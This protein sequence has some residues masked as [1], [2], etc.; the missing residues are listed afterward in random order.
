MN[1]LQP[2]LGQDKSNPLFEILLNPKI[3]DLLF[4]YFGMHLLEKINRASLEEKFLV[5]RLFNAKFSRKEL[6]KTF[7]Y[8][9]KTM[10]KWG[11]ALHTGNIE[12]ILKVFSGNL[13]KRKITKDIEKFIRNLYHE[14]YNEYGCHS[15]EYIRSRVE[16]IFEVPIS[17]ESIRIILREEKSKFLTE[18]EKKE[19]GFLPV[20]HSAASAI[21]SK[22]K[23]YFD[24]ISEG[25]V[26]A[27]NVVKMEC[28][29]GNDDNSGTNKDK[30]SKYIPIL[31]PTVKSLPK[32]NLFLHHAGLLTA[33]IFIDETTMH[34][35]ADHHNTA[36]QW[37]SMILCGCINIEQGQMLNYK[38]L[39]FLLGPQICSSLRQRKALINISIEQNIWELLRE[40]IRLVGAEFNDYFLYDPHSI[41]YT[42]QVKTLK[43]WIGSSH[44]TGKVYYQDFMHTVEGAPVFVDLDDNFYDLRGRFIE[45]INKFRKI[46]NGDK[47][48]PLNIIVDRAIY[49]VD[50]MKSCRTHNIFIITW[51]K[52]YR[53][54]R[55][56]MEFEE[57]AVQFSI[58]RYKNSNDDC[59]AYT[60]KYVKSVWEKDSSFV[61]YTVMLIKNKND[62]IELSII[63]SDVNAEDQKCIYFLLK[64]WVQEND[65]LILIRLGINQITSYANYS[66]EEI[67]ERIVD[68]ECRNKK[69]GKL[70]AERM[71]LRKELGL[72]LVKRE[73][74]I[75]EKNNMEC[76]LNKQIH[77]IE[78]DIKTDEHKNKSSRF[79]E[80]TVLKKKQYKALKNIDC[81]KKAVLKRN[82]DKQI[83][84]RNKIKSID[85]ELEKEPEFVSRLK[86]LM[87]DNYRKLNFMQK[88]YMDAIKITSRNIIYLMLPIFRVLYNNR[89]NDLKLL[90]E[91]IKADGI[92]EENEDRMIIWLIISRRYNPK[93]KKAVM[94]LL[95]T[96]SCK[97]NQLYESNKPILFQIHEL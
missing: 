25:K 23:N 2:F 67:A 30:K 10:K 34:L 26:E 78:K 57:K 16:D 53:K 50:F 92:I 1:I 86:S 51:E 33:R 75:E 39:E 45:N 52:N 5:A 42:G 97:I 87:G 21:S 7:G 14:I 60:V 63:C 40:N 32:N 72:L 12:Y 59:Y 17:Y 83:K 66:Y 49:D 27:E 29:G 3:P 35:S 82:S 20:L 73:D 31:Y 18:P 85:T 58:V 9:Y 54:G 6:T 89:R 77:G 90:L 84:L 94:E 8:D 70:L 46:L 56:D 22:I 13:A 55:W 93:Q 24:N 91:I 74:Y 88:T 81:N 47:N 65:M 41:P 44:K 36:R 4:V 15:N 43:G 28:S 95:F 64:R 79:D 80:L 69:Y 19:E 62:F 48:R 61:Q 76:E 68:K 38:S 71:K 11:S 37:I 96:L